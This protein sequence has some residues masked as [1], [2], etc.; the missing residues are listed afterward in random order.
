MVEVPSR[1]D[2]QLNAAAEDALDAQ[3]VQAGKEYLDALHRLGLEP[4]VLCWV[5]DAIESEIELAIVT[6]MAERIESLEIYRLLFRAYEA[7]AT[8]REID[9][10]IVSIYGPNSSFG[11]TL[12]ESISNLTTDGA[13]SSLENTKRFVFS[14]EGPARSKFVLARGVYTRKELRKS[15]AEDLRRWGRF[16]RNVEAVAA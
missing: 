11:I 1:V 13:F 10:F 8:P 4:D 14:I 16:K 7:A 15:A 2:P 6:S 5:Y 9:P 3:R 12:R